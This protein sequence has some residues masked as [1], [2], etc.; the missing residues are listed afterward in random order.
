MNYVYHL[1][2]KDMQGEVLY[3]LNKLKTIFP[4]L[5]NKKIEKYKGREHLTREVI[6]FLNCLWNDVLHFSAVNPYDIK[7]AFTELG[8]PFKTRFYKVEAVSLKT[9]KTIVYLFN[10]DDKNGKLS[11]SEFEKYC[12]EAISKY[13]KLP[14]KTKKYYKSELKKER[15]PLLFYKIPH[16]LFKGEVNIKNASIISV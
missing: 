3:P 8:H 4:E 6:P 7:K 14:S 13:S 5:Y 10:T 2:P 1:V 9:E 15:W 11:E 16:I 12:P